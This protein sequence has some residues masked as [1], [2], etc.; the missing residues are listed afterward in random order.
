MIMLFNLKS[1]R[2]PNQYRQEWDTNCSWLTKPLSMEWRSSSQWY[3]RITINKSQRERLDDNSTPKLQNTLTFFN[4]C[5]GS[6][7]GHALKGWWKLK[8]GLPWSLPYHYMLTTKK[9]VTSVDIIICWQK[10]NNK[11]TTPS[12]DS[13]LFISLEKEDRL[14]WQRLLLVVPFQN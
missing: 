8:Y 10:N 6:K 1:F 4:R 13:I 12:V 2:P 9:T 14:R 7:E 11:K 3:L 5:M